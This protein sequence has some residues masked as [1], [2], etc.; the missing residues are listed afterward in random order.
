MKDDTL[1]IISSLQEISSLSEL[2]ERFPEEWEAVQQDISKTISRKNDAVDNRSNGRK[3]T[4]KGLPNSQP[5]NKQ[6]RD[7]LVSEKIRKR[8]MHLFL[9]DQCVSAAI[10][11]K[12]G[13]IRFNLINGFLV[14]KL[15]FSHGLER[16]PASLFWFRLIWPLIRQKRYLM[17][18]VEPKGIYCF[19][20][21]ELV[22]ALAAIIGSKSCL[23]IA[24]GDGTLTRF[25][26]DQGAHIEATDNQTWKHSLQYPDAVHNCD[27]K[28]ALRNYKPEVV[29]CSWP[30]AN[31]DFERSIFKTDSVQ[32]Y[33]LIASRYE[34]ASGNW[35]DYRKQTTF[36]LQEDKKLSQLVLPP[37][38]ECAVYI[39]QR[40]QTL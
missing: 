9:K 3:R 24:A 8:M 20:S 32:T 5:K 27:A 16:K 37:E 1:K 31:N 21:R 14:Q 28:V 40:K 34:F 23:E 30:P 18:L 12:Q 15:L 4:Y 36:S 29:V 25:L 38:L 6:G 13:K 19:Y 22:K 2:C 26:K 10:G 35:T 17:P 7:A 39:F 11:V 33:I